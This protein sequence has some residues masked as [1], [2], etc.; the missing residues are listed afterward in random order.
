[1]SDESHGISKGDAVRVDSDG[2][3][4]FDTPEQIEFFKLMTLRRLM[5]L[6]SKGVRF[7]RT[8]PSPLF[9]LKR[10]YGI[11]ARTF[12]KGLEEVEALISNKFKDGAIR[13]GTPV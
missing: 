2:A 8:T 4:I 10:D 1:M 6:R 13:P 9:V 3:V 5:D 11:T 12:A 7:S